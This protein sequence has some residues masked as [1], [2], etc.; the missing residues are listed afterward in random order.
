MTYGTVALPRFGT[1]APFAVLKPAALAEG[2][3]IWRLEAGQ[4]YTCNG[5][6]AYAPQSGH[7]E[8]MKDKF[9]DEL[10]EVRDKYR[11]WGPTS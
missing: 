3:W 10:Q 6:N 7:E 5:I 4:S 9:Y 8:G 2:F 11:N 1:L